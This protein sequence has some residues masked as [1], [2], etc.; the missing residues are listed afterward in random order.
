MVLLSSNE[1]I[2]Y[3]KTHVDKPQLE[4]P[5]MN[6][7]LNCEHNLTKQRFNMFNFCIYIRALTQLFNSTA[8]TNTKHYLLT[9]LTN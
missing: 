1:C 9:Q 5:M 4:A 3:A 7:L 2:H 6:K 8:T